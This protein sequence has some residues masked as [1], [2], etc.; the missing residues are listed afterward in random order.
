MQNRNPNSGGVRDRVTV[1]DRVGA[2]AAW[3]F[4]CFDLSF[5]KFLFL[6]FA[7]FRLSE[8]GP[9]HVSTLWKT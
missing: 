2:K 3:F 6:S 7:R 5:L 8:M 1:R 9:I 4:F